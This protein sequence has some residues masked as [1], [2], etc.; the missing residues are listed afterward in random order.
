MT[1]SQDVRNQSLDNILI[2]RIL[3]NT[4][5]RI[6]CKRIRNCASIFFIEPLIACFTI[7]FHVRKLNFVF[8][9]G[10]LLIRVQR[11]FEFSSIKA[12]LLGDFVFAIWR[13]LIEIRVELM[14]IS[15]NWKFY[16]C[17]LFNLR[18]SIWLGFIPS[19]DK[20]EIFN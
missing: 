11:A 19:L 18:E 13:F 1:R 4:K 9:V 7:M 5:Y 20:L 2:F 16:Y 17:F 10:K 8:S 12:L 3:N 6:I 14:W 15:K